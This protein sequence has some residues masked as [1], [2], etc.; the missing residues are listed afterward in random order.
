MKKSLRLILIAV[1][2]VCLL[3]FIIYLLPPVK[4]RVDT[5][6]DLLQ[7]EVRYAINPPEEAVFVP[8]G[9]PLDIDSAVTATLQ[10][11]L[12]PSVTVTPEAENT[13]A[14]AE[15]GPTAE[16]TELPPPT[17]T[18]EPLPASARIDGVEYQHQ[19]G[20]WNYCG[21]ANLAMAVSFWGWE[22]DRQEV[23]E[24]V[25]GS[26]ERVDDKNIMPYEMENYVHSQTGLG[27]ISRTGGSL[28]TLKRLIV[29]GYPVIVEKQ[30]VLVNIG[31]LGHY[32][33]LVGYDDET[34]TFISMDAYHGEGTRYSYQE[35]EQAWRAFN[36]TFLVTYPPE[37]EPELLA[38]LGPFADEDWSKQHALD[39]AND[40]LTRLDGLQLYFAW[41]NRGTSL[42]ALQDY[43]SAAQAYDTAFG[44]YAELDEN[45]RP[46]R[47][48]WYQTG[49][50]F[51]YYFT[52]RYQ[53]VI[54]LADQTL[55]GMNEPILEESFYW[56]GLGKEAIGDW[57]GA[58]ADIQT[59]VDLNP[60]FAPGLDQLDRMLGGG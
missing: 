19:H 41:F 16:P 34:E 18:L 55:D 2:A 58:L 36:Y 39:L 24:V 6:I 13:E 38:A 8:Q 56:R 52:A 43:A 28:E 27:L 45:I 30:D 17:A 31:W 22:V 4:S 14:I 59:S 49:P 37:Q 26:R 44:L 11:L 35:L 60:Q 15:A 33:L 5:R 10:A 50:Y 9:Q 57:E 23:G 51:A 1:P 7:A 54:A 47:M 46:W 12:E 40:E 3:T 53:D 21:P 29:A 20:L 48:L 32:L 42:V 25:R